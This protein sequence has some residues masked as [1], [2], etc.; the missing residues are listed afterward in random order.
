M[1]YHGVKLTAIIE[2]LLG[3]QVPGQG[4]RHEKMRDLAH[5]LRY[6]CD[7]SPKKVLEALKTQEWVNDLIGEG[8]PVEATVEGACRLKYGRKK[9][10]ELQKALEELGEQ[11]SVTSP[12]P[13]CRRWTIPSPTGE[14]QGEV[15][16]AGTSPQCS[17][18]VP[19]KEWG[20]EIE[21]MFG[22]YPCLKE[23]CE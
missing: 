12:S 5:Q 4:D 22:V 6:V 3:G 1:S 7:N 13:S 14:G 18:D 15:I 21:K 10:E 2:K 9:P 16:I 20:E 23:I 19:L 17:A 11:G 8:D